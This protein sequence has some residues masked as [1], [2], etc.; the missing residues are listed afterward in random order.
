MRDVL[1][2]IAEQDEGLAARLTEGLATD[3]EQ[4]MV[5]A[6]FIHCISKDPLGRE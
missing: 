1:E 5:V 2:L 6:L 4:R 3:D